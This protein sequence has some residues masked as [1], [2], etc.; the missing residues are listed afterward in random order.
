MAAGETAITELLTPV[1]HDNVPVQ[2]E[3]VRFTLPPAHTVSLLA[4]I[5]G[6]WIPGVT[7]MVTGV[8]VR[9]P[10]ALD[11][12]VAEYVPVVVGFMLIE[13]PVMALDQ[14]RVPVQP[15]AVNTTVSP[16]HIVFLLAVIVGAVPPVVPTVIEIGDE[17]LLVHEFVLQTAV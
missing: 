6:V 13:V 12:Q 14:V 17:G 3:T 2:L 5:T 15:L 16:L 10:Q 1:D 4:V 8:E 7:V 11:A 9:L